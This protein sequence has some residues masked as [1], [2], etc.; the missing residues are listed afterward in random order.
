M[1]QMLKLRAIYGNKPFYIHAAQTG[2]GEVYTLHIGTDKE[3]SMHVSFWSETD[4]NAFIE[5]LWQNKFHRDESKD[6][7][8]IV[9]ELYANDIIENKDFKL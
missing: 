9:G 5:K 8:L 6:N 1:I 4:L 7:S 2:I 3:T